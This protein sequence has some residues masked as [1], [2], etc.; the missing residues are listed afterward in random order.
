MVIFEGVPGRRC[1]LGCKKRDMLGLPHALSESASGSSDRAYRVPGDQR[2][3][4]VFALCQ[5]KRSY[6]ST[7]SRRPAPTRPCEDP[8]NG[9][10]VPIKE[11]RDLVQRLA[12]LPSVPHQGL[13]TF[14][15]LDPVPSLHPQHSLLQRQLSVCCI[16]HMN[17]RLKTDAALT[18][19]NHLGRGSKALIRD[20]R[21]SS[22]NR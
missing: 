1:L 11:P 21:R 8:A 15:V 10:V 5:A 22:P 3:R 2:P 9:R 18:A 7:A 6:R 12:F 13:L 4:D 16:D 17:P 14:C 20:R 19:G